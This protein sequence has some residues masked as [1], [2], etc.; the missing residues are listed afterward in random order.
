[1]LS[2]LTPLKTSKMS[3]VIIKCNIKFINCLIISCLVGPTNGI[4]SH[5][6]GDI[7]HVSSWN[8]ANRENEYARCVAYVPGEIWSR[9]LESFMITLYNIFLS[10]VAHFQNTGFKTKWIFRD[11]VRTQERVRSHDNERNSTSSPTPWWIPISRSRTYLSS[12]QR[13]EPPHWWVPPVSW[14]EECHSELIPAP[15]AG[16]APIRLAIP[17]RRHFPSLR[18]KHPHLRWR[19]TRLRCTGC[20][21]FCRHATEDLLSGTHCCCLQQQTQR[22]NARS[23]GNDYKDEETGDNTKQQF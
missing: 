19:C 2:A 9:G 10:S 7:K 13:L 23:V 6:S 15:P 14:G 5:A 8:I 11:M 4:C 21:Q 3:W 17:R 18:R 12:S 22:L 16:Q 20:S 1:M